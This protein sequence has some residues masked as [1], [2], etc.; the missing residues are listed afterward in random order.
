MNYDLLAKRI[1]EPYVFLYLSLHHNHIAQ[2][3][4]FINVFRNCNVI[5]NARTMLLVEFG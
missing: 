4:V 5:H 2:W 3:G 1:S